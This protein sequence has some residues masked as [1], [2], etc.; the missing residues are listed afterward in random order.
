MNF[1]KNVLK[2]NLL[3]IPGS[4]EIER[5]CHDQWCIHRCSSSVLPFTLIAQLGVERVAQLYAPS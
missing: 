1:Y 3:L 2:I 4:D 5:L